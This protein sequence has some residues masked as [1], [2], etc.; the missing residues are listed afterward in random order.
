MRKKQTPYASLFLILLFPLY[1]NGQA[2]TTQEVSDIVKQFLSTIQSNSVKQDKAAEIKKVLHE[3]VLL[4]TLTKNEISLLGQ[5]MLNNEISIA[6]FIK[7][8]TGHNINQF[9]LSSWVLRK[10]TLEKNIQ[11][12]VI[13]GL[14]NEKDQT[15]Y[16][17]K[18]NLET[19]TESHPVKNKKCEIDVVRDRDGRLKIIGFIL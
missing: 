17:I 1:L 10:Y 11:E 14:K 12:D 2:P 15:I 5:G 7:K 13:K 3:E 9:L 19:R 4:T 6:A 16:Y 18:A 8:I